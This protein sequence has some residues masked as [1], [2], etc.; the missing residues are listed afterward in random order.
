MHERDI[1]IVAQGTIYPSR[2]MIHD[3][4]IDQSHHIVVTTNTV[5]LSYD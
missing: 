5:F 4:P 1:V 2:I 3:I